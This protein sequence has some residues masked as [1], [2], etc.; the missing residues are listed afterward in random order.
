MSTFAITQGMTSQ[1]AAALVVIDWAAVRCREAKIASTSHEASALRPA[2]MPLREPEQ[3]LED[4][5][6]WDGLS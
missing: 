2:R 1:T 4:A 6:R 3:C 5:E